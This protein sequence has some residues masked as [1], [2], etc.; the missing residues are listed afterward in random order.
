[1]V[2]AVSPEDELPDPP[3]VEQWESSHWV[4][5]SGRRALN[6]TT[7]DFLG[8]GSD[9]GVL[10][11]ARATVERY[12]VGS[13]GPRGFYGTFDV[14]LDLER[15]LAKFMGEEEAII[16]SYDIAT[17]ASVIPA[18]ASRA[19]VLVMDEGCGYPVQQGAKL[20]RARVYTFKHNDADDLAALL[21]R[22]EAEERRER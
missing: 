6:L 1:M 15:D 5:V 4:T 8:L 2:P 20:S 10:A 18:F 11:A 22:L 16:Y 21:A 7:A 17:V 3:T 14:H 12:G 13:C 9:P 19:D